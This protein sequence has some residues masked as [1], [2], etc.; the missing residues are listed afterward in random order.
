MPPMMCTTSPSTSS[1]AY[2]DLGK[3][4]HDLVEIV[5][6]VGGAQ[7]CRRHH[8]H[9]KSHPDVQVDEGLELISS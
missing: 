6:L 2:I 1:E 5:R 9:H 7:A 3:A 8:H 4:L